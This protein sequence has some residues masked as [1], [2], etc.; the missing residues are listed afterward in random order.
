VVKSEL[1]ESKAVNAIHQI[2]HLNCIDKNLF[3]VNLIFHLRI[4]PSRVVDE[5]LER[6]YKASRWSE[7]RH[8]HLRRGP[9]LGVSG[10]GIEALEAGIHQQF[11]D[12]DTC[13]TGRDM[14][15]GLAESVGIIDHGS[16]TK[17]HLKNGRVAVADSFGQRAV[18]VLVLTFDLRALAH[19]P[20]RG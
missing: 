20:F 12:P 6:T 2:T 8:K 10:H 4:S 15:H 11:D 13:H 5:A 3:L 9:V 17:Q 1:N 16:I 19:S 14:K 18:V 7:P